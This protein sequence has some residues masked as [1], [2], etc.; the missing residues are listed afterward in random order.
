MLGYFIN[1]FIDFY[2]APMPMTLE[3]SLALVKENNKLAANAMVI[4]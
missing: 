1:W 3:D 4:L 2:V